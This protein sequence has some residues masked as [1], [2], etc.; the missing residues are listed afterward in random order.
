M[1]KIKEFFK[2]LWKKIKANP[3]SFIGRVVLFVLALVVL[4]CSFLP[5]D[6]KQQ[7][8]YAE[9]APYGVVRVNEFYTTSKYVSY[10]V[11]FPASIYADTGDFVSPTSLF[12]SYFSSG[13]TVSAPVKFA[14]G[15]FA[16]DCLVTPLD[17]IT[18]PFVVY[19]P[20]SSSTSSG[21]LFEYEFSSSEAVAYIFEGGVSTRVSGG[22]TLYFQWNPN[23]SKTNLYTMYIGWVDETDV[24]LTVTWGVFSDYFQIY[25]YCYSFDFDYLIGKGVSFPL[26]VNSSI[27]SSTYIYDFFSCCSLNF[28]S[29]SAYRNSV[30]SSYYYGQNVY[31]L[32]DTTNAYN[33]GY[34]A[35]YSA[36]DAD[37]YSRGFTTGK[38]EGLSEGYNNGYDV[39]LKAGETE[40]YGKGYDKGYEDGLNDNTSYDTGWASG[41]TAGRN[42]A[43]TEGL[44]NPVVYILQPVSTFLDTKLFGVVSIGQMLSVALFVMIAVI[45][46]KMFA[47][48]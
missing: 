4:I 10:P 36:G 19:K 28:V 46:L 17:N 26:S 14:N 13:S 38:Q 30:Y 40:G 15:T 43:L 47:G 39:G 42:E 5:K 9:T 44:T 3:F 41:H 1:N 27:T 24:A 48:G 32:N 8:A 16:L 33:A 20:P 31:N 45:F 25:S 7:S 35:G 18:L 29:S 12:S 22:D 23:S 11:M 6:N 34:N 21:S 2:N 37:G